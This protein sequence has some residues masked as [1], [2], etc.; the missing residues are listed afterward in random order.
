M[1]IIIIIIII[2]SFLINIDIIIREGKLQEMESRAEK[3]E[4]GT[5]IFQVRASPSPPP[6]L[7]LQI[8][9]DVAENDLFWFSEVK[10]E[11][12]EKRIFG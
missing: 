1:I 3:L 2:I 11:G 4:Q 12:E 8:S 10:Q 9:A 5:V 7:I 6:L